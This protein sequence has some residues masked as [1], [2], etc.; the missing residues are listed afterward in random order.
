M[1]Y[2]PERGEREEGEEREEGHWSQ[3]KVSVDHNLQAYGVQARG[4]SACTDFRAQC[5]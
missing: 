2:S 4:I 5:T 1:P 3:S